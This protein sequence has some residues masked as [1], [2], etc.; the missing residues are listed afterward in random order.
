MNFMKN[1][2]GSRGRAYLR[3]R[4]SLQRDL[5][6]ALRR[7][8]ALPRRAPEN[9]PESRSNPGNMVWIFGSGRSGSTWLG[10]MMGELKG[11]ALW[12]EPQ[13]GSMF[14]RFYHE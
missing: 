14:G 3:D 10:L 7:L 4:Q 9:G 5:E 2:P 1:L 13:V 11:Y 6:K 8:G 12:N